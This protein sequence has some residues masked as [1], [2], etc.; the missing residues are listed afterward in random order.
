M[1]IANIDGQ[2]CHIFWTTVGISMEF[3][4]KMCLM[5]VSKVTKNQG[6]TLSLSLKDWLFAKTT[7]GAGG[8][9]GEV[10]IGPPQSF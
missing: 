10:Q 6:F 1:K 3:S 5:I 2:N 9:G 4:G 8:G 7:D